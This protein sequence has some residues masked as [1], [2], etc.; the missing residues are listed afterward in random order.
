MGFG[1][2]HAAFFACSDEHKRRLPGRLIGVSKDSAGKPA[3]R[4]S[5]QTREQHI[6]R[7]KATSNICT[8]Q[9][10]LANM[11]AMYAVY[12]GPQGLRDIATRVHNLT[13]LL[14]EGVRRL[15]HTVR[16]Q[17]FFDTI[18]ID[19]PYSSEELIKTAEQNGINIRRLDVRTVAVSLDEAVTREDIQRLLQVFAAPSVEASFQKSAS[20]LKPI[21]PDLAQLERELGMTLAKPH[22]IPQTFMRQSA[23][24]THPVFNTYHSETEMLRYMNRLQAKDLSLANSMIP[25]GSCTMKLNSTT[26]MLPVTWPEFARLHPFVPTNQSEGYKIMLQVRW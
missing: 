23:Y 8:A 2:P 26:E 9:A 14:A 21:V 19:L 24:L 18:A 16:N 25:L 6:R 3:Y 4:L 13:C 20:E 22:G 15:G 7:E 11:S 5:L 1:G 12:H 17:V 10:L